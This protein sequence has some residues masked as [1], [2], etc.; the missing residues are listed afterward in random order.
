MLTY[1]LGRGLEAGDRTT[2]DRAIQRLGENGYRFSTLVTEI[3]NSKPFR[4][5]KGEG[6][7][8]VR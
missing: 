2:V 5:N 1:A 7:G 4:M 3:A 6:D 8:N